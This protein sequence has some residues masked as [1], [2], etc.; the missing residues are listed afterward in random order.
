MQSSIN[1]LK[2]FAESRQIDIID[3]SA[4]SILNKMSNPSGN[5]YFNCNQ[6]LNDDSWV[7]SNQPNTTYYSIPCTSSIGKYGD[8]FTCPTG[9]SAGNPCTGCMDTG[10]ISNYY[11]RNPSSVILD[12]L[13]TRYTPNCSFNNELNNIWNNYYLVKAQALGPDVQGVASNTGVLPRMI[14]VKNDIDSLISN[15]DP[16][17]PNIF[18]TIL[19]DL[20]NINNIIDPKY[21]LIAGLN[22]KLMGENFQRF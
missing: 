9:V 15:M 3:N 2:D 11:Y 18:N 19:S 1:I 20:S 8:E 10:S 16:A 21:G 17:L 4:L 6:L 12:D 5:G 14:I 22:C 13:N 7:P